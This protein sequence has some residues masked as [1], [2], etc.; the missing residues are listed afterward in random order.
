MDYPNIKTLE[1][2]EVTSL[3]DLDVA[4]LGA[5]ELFQ[6][7]P[8][9]KID[10]SAYKKPLVVGSGN[11]EATGKI[12]FREADAVFA[13]ESDFEEKLKYI[14]DIDGVVLISASGEK[15][16]PIIARAAKKYGKHVT[17]ITNTPNSSASKELDHE[18]EYDE[19][20]L[21]KNREPYTYN[22]STYLGMIL[23][24]TEENPAEIMQFITEEIDRIDFS[25]LATYDRFF[26]IVPSEF[27]EAI[28]MLHV[29]F[30]ELFARTVARDI[31]TT[32]YLRHAAT[33][34]PSHELFISFGKKNE[35]WGAPE[36]RLH[37]PLPK[38]AGY[39]TMVAVG[40]Y[41]IAQIQKSHPP[42]FKEN[43]TPYTEKV[44][45]LFGTEVTS[46]VE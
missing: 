34:V 4:V 16:A 20:V 9:V 10:F 6:K 29:K 15:H 32:E 12:L 44:S 23:G 5:L 7:T 27:S 13:S 30:I 14:K 25:S 17:L 41:V 26:L 46:I 28:R 37:I 24:A 11:A 33:V 45:R 36:N 43:I 1:T 39:A 18:H 40:Y 35:D 38:N 19:Y 3:P 2:F 21:P 42:Y 8:I 31:E 22:T